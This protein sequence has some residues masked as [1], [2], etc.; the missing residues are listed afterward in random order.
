MVS[1]ELTEN[2]REVLRKEGKT[3]PWAIITEP[4]I[5]PM[6]L[7]VFPA[8]PFPAISFEKL[9]PDFNYLYTFLLQKYKLQK[10]PIRARYTDGFYY[11]YIGK[12][13]EKPKL[14]SDR[15]KLSE[16]L[17]RKAIIDIDRKIMGY[18]RK[19]F[20]YELHEIAR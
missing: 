1:S 5:I 7:V 2:D 8:D 18:L 17:Y 3:I 15:K 10:T 13:V 12:D 16:N 19:N 9:Y 11:E 20:H 4:T 14:L 6:S